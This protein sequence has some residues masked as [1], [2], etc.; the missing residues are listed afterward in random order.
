M[1][2]WLIL[3][4]L[5]FGPSALAQNTSDLQPA[6]PGGYGGGAYYPGMP[7]PQ[8]P[9]AAPAPGNAPAGGAAASTRGSVSK[10]GDDKPAGHLIYDELPSGNDGEGEVTSDKVA[11][12]HV[13]KKG[14]T[15]WDISSQYFRNPYYWPKLWAYNPSITNPHWIYPGDIVRLSAAGTPV[16]APPS[17]PEPQ[18]TSRRLSAR[19]MD[20]T[21]LFLRQTGF[22]EPGELREAGTIVGSKEEKIMLSTLDEAYVGFKPEKPLVVGEKYSVYRPVSEVKHPITGKRVGDIVQIFGEVEVKSVTPG[23]IARVQII[24][25]TEG[26]ERGYRVGPLRRQFKVVEPRTDTNDLS[27]VVV[28]TLQPRQMVGTDMLVVLDR[29]KKDGVEI[30]NRF[31]VVRR[32]DGYQP[33]LA[34]NGPVDDKRFPRETVAE[35]L[36]IEPREAI[37]IGIVTHADKEARIGDRIE[38]RKGF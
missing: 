3:T 14:D 18:P 31:L 33:M 6:A 16:A 10:A 35:I 21:G 4:A 27:G 24:D 17:S 32:G 7:I 1:N 5:V 30:G 12:T 11:D 37:A 8:A 13:V 25:C 9:A 36:V 2:R 38:A 23:N 19:P 26:M 22:V 28:A 34:R 20:A 15:L 29:G